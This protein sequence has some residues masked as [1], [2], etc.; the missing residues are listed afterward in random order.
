MVVLPAILFRARSVLEWEAES[1][2]RLVV[3]VENLVPNFVEEIGKRTGMLTLSLS[4]AT[5]VAFCH[6]WLALLFLY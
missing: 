6:H 3:L 2:I 4:A 5:F 1:R